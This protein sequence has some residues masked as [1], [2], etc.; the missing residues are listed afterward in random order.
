M[1]C[2][3]GSTIKGIPDNV[4]E[5]ITI[6]GSRADVKFD[7]LSR[8]KIPQELYDNEGKDKRTVI[9]RSAVHG[10]WLTGYFRAHANVGSCGH[11]KQYY[12]KDSGWYWESTTSKKIKFN[13]K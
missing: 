2:G 12:Q 9:T 7:T 6:V 10:P 13:G 8:K 4:R 1:A 11:A 3:Q 5:H